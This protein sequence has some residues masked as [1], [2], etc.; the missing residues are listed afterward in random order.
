MALRYAK[1]ALDAPEHEAIL[2]EYLAYCDTL[3]KPKSTIKLPK[4][5]DVDDRSFLLLAVACKADTLITGD[6]ELLALAGAAPLRLISQHAFLR[7][8]GKTGF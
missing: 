5:R 2:A 8:I 4:H 6:N 7:G 1:F 3:P